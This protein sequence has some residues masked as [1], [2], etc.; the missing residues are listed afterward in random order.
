MT[1]YAL[2]DHTHAA[3][4]GGRGGDTTCPLGP[5]LN[6]SVVANRTPSAQTQLARD[7]AA[8]SATHDPAEAEPFIVRRRTH[9]ENPRIVGD[10]EYLQRHPDAVTI[11]GRTTVAA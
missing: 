10:A 1:A 3:Q 7:R 2:I 8:W 6:P 11:A 4:E 5:Y 9:P